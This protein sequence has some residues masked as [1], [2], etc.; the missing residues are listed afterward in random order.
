M[1]GRGVSSVFSIS[2]K[3]HAGKPSRGTTA[4]FHQSVVHLLDLLCL[5]LVSS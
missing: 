2:C 1:E 4:S 3:P 5:V